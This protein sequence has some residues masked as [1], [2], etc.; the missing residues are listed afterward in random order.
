MPAEAG[1]APAC[2]MG[3]TGLRVDIGSL[4]AD[5]GGVTAMTLMGRLDFDGAVPVPV[6]V[7]VDKR[8]HP[9]TGLVFAHI[10]PG[11]GRDRVRSS[12]GSLPGHPELRA[13]SGASVARAERDLRA[14]DFSPQ[15]AHLV[16][17]VRVRSHQYKRVRRGGGPEASQPQSPCCSPVGMHGN[18]AVLGAAGSAVASMLGAM[19][20]WDW[21]PPHIWLRSEL[22]HTI[23]PY[24]IGCRLQA[25]PAGA[26]F[27]WGTWTRAGSI[28]G[29]QSRRIGGCKRNREHRL[30]GHRRLH[31][32]CFSPDAIV[33]R[34]VSLV[35]VTLNGGTDEDTLL[36]QTQQHLAGLP[37][38]GPPLF[39]CNENHRFNCRAEADG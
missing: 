1:S 23:Q 32:L 31:F 20:Q 13:D 38:L 25:G 18:L 7:P 39:I 34:A 33:N 21:P 2:W 16:G 4:P 24:A 11:A 5:C 22:F 14:R 3:P 26:A 9:L 30:H 6:G 12:F 10:W 17:C 36:L 35:P 28:R 19:I 27:W 29:L 8:H 37:G 15:P